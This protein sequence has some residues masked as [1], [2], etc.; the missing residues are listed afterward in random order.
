M[1]LNEAFAAVHCIISRHDIAFTLPLK[2]NLP[3]RGSVHNFHRLSAPVCGQNSHF[4]LLRES[5]LISFP[6]NF[7]RDIIPAERWPFSAQRDFAIIPVDFPRFSPCKRYLVEHFSGVYATTRYH[8]GT[9]SSN[10]YRHTLDTRTAL[11]STRRS[12]TTTS[13]RGFAEKPRARRIR[14]HLETLYRVITRVTRGN[15]QRRGTE[16]PRIPNPLFI[17]HFGQAATRQRHS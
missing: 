13:V 8:R 3:I 4:P 15:T 6:R 16:R 11:I 12:L 9:W 14:R 2:C 7:S 17:I 5:S 10:R 1:A